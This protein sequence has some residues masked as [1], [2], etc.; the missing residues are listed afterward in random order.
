MKR[1][2]L[3]PLILFAFSNSNSYAATCVAVLENGP[4]LGD[5]FA[6]VSPQA[7][8]N[9]YDFYCAGTTE[10][11]SACGASAF[12]VRVTVEDDSGECFVGMTLPAGVTCADEGLVD[13][14]SG[15]CGDPPPDPCLA[16][17][18]QQDFYSCTRDTYSEAASCAEGAALPN[19]C[20]LETTVDPIAPQCTQTGIPVSQGGTG[21]EYTCVVDLT[22][23]GQPADPGDGLP[24][25]DSDDPTT[26]EEG[27]II[28]EETTDDNGCNSTVYTT[29]EITNNGD[30]TVT[31]CRITDTIRTGASCGNLGDTTDTDCST[32][33]GDG[34]ST[35]TTSSETRDENQVVTDSTSSSSDVGPPSE[36]PAEDEGTYT[37]GGN[38]DSPPSCSG[39]TLQCA[40]IEQQFAARCDFVNSLD[41]FT[42]DDTGLVVSTTEVDV[43]DE[44]TGF[45]NTDGWLS[46]RSCPTVAPVTIAGQ[47]LTWSFEGVC[48]AFSALSF[49]VLGFAGFSGIRVFMG[50]F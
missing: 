16:S 39:D 22:G 13:D 3:L 25:T 48:T 20:A 45:L 11:L 9:Y 4:V 34:S 24:Q 8:N 18:G 43:D 46:N 44:I 2:L 30:G 19:G 7:D 31:R 41:G 14:G 38:C 49:L 1:Y 26:S 17:S 50:A 10:L 21:I 33:Y 36:E 28:E 12:D 27:D 35:N 37:A 42:P 32:T 40:I 15:S 5:V 47:T 6:I 23:T 29:T